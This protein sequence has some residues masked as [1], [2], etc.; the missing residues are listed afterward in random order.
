MGKGKGG[1]KG[2]WQRERD[3]VPDWDDLEFLMTKTLRKAV[4]WQEGAAKKRLEL[5]ADGDFVRACQGHS[6][7]SGLT[8]KGFELANEETLPEDDTILVHGTFRERVVVSITTDGLLPSGLGSGEGRL[9]VHW[10][11]DAL[12]KPGKHTGVRSGTD[13]V[14]ITTVGRLREGR[15]DMWT[16]VDG[17][18]LTSEVPPRCFDRI[19]MF[20]GETGKE[21]DLLWTCQD[22]LVPIEL[23]TGDTD[24]SFSEDEAEGRQRSGAASSQPGRGVKE[25]PEEPDHLLSEQH[26]EEMFKMEARYEEQRQQAK[27]APPQPEREAATQPAL[28][29]AANPVKQEELRAIWSKEGRTRTARLVESLLGGAAADELRYQ[30]G[31]VGGLSQLTA[32]QEERPTEGGAAKLEGSLRMITSATTTAAVTRKRSGLPVGDTESGAIGEAVTRALPV[33]AERP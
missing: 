10:S 21:G 13:A 16:G 22:G 11:K 4:R 12:D 30:E 1:R 14:V 5:S 24:E 20:D 19:S 6:S 18:I 2:R 15:V 32:K 3:P 8:A 31:A 23:P 7:D 9:F 29:A 33:A 26:I 25:D 17:I 27:A 28:P